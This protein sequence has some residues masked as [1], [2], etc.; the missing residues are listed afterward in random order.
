[1]MPCGTLRQSKYDFFLCNNYSLKCRIW[2]LKFFSDTPDQ[3]ILIT[4]QVISLEFVAV[5]SELSSREVILILAISQLLY[6]S[7]SIL[8]YSMCQTLCGLATLQG[9]ENL[10]YGQLLNN[11]R[12]LLLYSHISSTG[13]WET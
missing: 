7:E 8:L 12:L 2:N 3:S 1:M 9:M 4:A 10:P 13:F 6:I 5:F 11:S